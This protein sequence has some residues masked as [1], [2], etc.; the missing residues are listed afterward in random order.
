MQNRVASAENYRWAIETNVL[1]WG[2]L[3]PNISVEYAF[4]DRWSASLNFD[5]AWWKQSSKDRFYQL[6]TLGPE[7][8]YWFGKPGSYRGFY[9]GAYAFS[10]A[11]DLKNGREGYW[12]E[13]LVAAG[14]S[15]GYAV[16]LSNRL[17]FRFG[18]GAGYLDTRFQKYV[19]YDD[20]GDHY[21]YDGTNRLKYW[22]VTKAEASL[23]WKF[24]KRK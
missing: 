18:I 10:G 9:M 22:G 1:Y 3:R 23:R 5:I 2:I 24:G 11:Y 17:A 16:R 7:I 13:S 15:V 19:R 20:M 21:V 8:R 6:W 12:S 14:L 4:A